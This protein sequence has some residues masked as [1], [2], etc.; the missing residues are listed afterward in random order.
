[1]SFYWLVLG[2]LGVWRITHLVQAEDGPFD[3]GVRLRRRL[4]NGFF[5][6][7]V[8]CFQCA[9]L[10]VA[11]PF[12]LTLGATHGERALL[13]VALSGG[14][15]LLERATG[16]KVAPPALY[17]E[18]PLPRDSGDRPTSHAVLQRETIAT[19]PDADGPGPH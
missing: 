7:L 1:M 17:F 15:I 8:D 14:A 18:D 10:W 2:V 13:F 19:L 16:Q 3:L 6:K 11:I 5:G 4:G 12:A 9:S